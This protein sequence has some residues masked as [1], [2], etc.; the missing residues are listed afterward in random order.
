M[1]RNFKNFLKEGTA[2]IKAIGLRRLFEEVNV[3]WKVRPESLFI[4][5]FSMLRI[6][7]VSLFFSSFLTLIYW[8]CF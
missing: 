7:N 6:Y 5:Q 1:R 2:C 4:E 3:D 8:N